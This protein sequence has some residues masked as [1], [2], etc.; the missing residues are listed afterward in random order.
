MTEYT[1]TTGRT[2][3]RHLQQ[4]YIRRIAVLFE[5]RAFSAF[6]RQSRSA[7]EDPRKLRDMDSTD[8]CTNMFA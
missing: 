6:L 3:N 2:R 5:R 7:K 4:A 8:T 1:V